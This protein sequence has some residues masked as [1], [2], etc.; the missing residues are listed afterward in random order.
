MIRYFA[1]PCGPLAP[2]HEAQTCVDEPD[3]PGREGSTRSVTVHDVPDALVA[4]IVRRAA[5]AGR[6]PQ[7]YLRQQLAD[8][9]GGDR[10][11]GLPDA[12]GG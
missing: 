10:D 11:G 7:E 5:R 1:Q 9:V 12:P 2:T 6:S 4:A 8:I 3:R